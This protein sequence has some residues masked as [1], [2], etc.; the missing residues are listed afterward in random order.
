M[1]PPK[2]IT[3]PFGKNAAGETINEIPESRAVGTPDYAATWDSGFPPITMQP[4]ASGGKAPQGPDFN[5][6]L[7]SI[8]EHTS[9]TC[10]GGFYKFDPVWVAANGGYEQG[11]ILQEN[12]GG[13]L[14][15]SLV[16]DNTLNFNTATE[17]EVDGLWMVAAG[18]DLTPLDEFISYGSPMW[19]A[20]RAPFSKGSIVNYNEKQWIS[21]VNDNNFT[22]VDGSSGWADISQADVEL[23]RRP[24]PLAPLTGGVSPELTGPLS[25]SPFAPIYS[26]DTRLH[27]VFEVT[28]NDDP[29][30]QSPV[31]TISVDADS[32]SISPPLLSSTFYLWRCQDVSV[33][34]EISPWSEIQS[35]T[36]AQEYIVEPTVISPANGSVNIPE[37]PVIQLSAFEVVGATDTHTGTSV[38]I[39]NNL[40][41]VIWEQVN[42]TPL[43]NITVPAGVLDP[44]STYTVEAMYHGATI[45]SSDWGMPSTFSTLNEFLPTVVGTPYGGGFY[46]GRIRSDYDGNVYALIVSG[47]TGDSVKLGV[48]P[49]VMKNSSTAITNTPLTPPMTLSDGK[50]NQVAIL[51]ESIYNHPACE[52][53]RDT[54]NAGAGLNG[55]KDWYIPSR[56]ELCLAYWGF[57]RQVQSV[58]SSRPLGGFGGGGESGQISTS[59]PSPYP[60]FDIGTPQASVVASFR[61]G[62]AD[63]FS[64]QDYWTTTERNASD[65]WRQ[66][67]NNGLQNSTSKTSALAARVVRRILVV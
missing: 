56:D 6:V 26:V 66:N 58:Q 37:R 29:T 43:N 39:K 11:A 35:F 50:A 32:T 7:N 31:F 12:T 8:S 1:I 4:L 55:Y 44:A 63:E 61:A 33:N 20:E 51:N 19:K 62:G 22:P 42:T 2:L 47:A 14:W 24:T 13:K 45:A 65:M 10:G 60:D 48:G 9:F 67:F 18:S 54:I 16:D 53:V 23:V 25:A 27:R 57:S 36:T 21:L 46:A 17:Q 30:F 3:T 5:G 52:W 41:S 38:R 15:L 49:F 40:G 59:F 34:G 28:L 64:A